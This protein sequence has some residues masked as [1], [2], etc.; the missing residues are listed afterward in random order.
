MANKR[1]SRF[2]KGAGTVA[3]RGSSYL[4]ERPRGEWIDRDTLLVNVYHEV[5]EAKR[6]LLTTHRNRINDHIES[7]AA[8]MEIF[9]PYDGEELSLLFEQSGKYWR[10]SMDCEVVTMEKLM[11]LYEQVKVVEN[12]IVAPDSLSIEDLVKRCDQVA[13][14]YGRG[15]LA[16]HYDKGYNVKHLGSIGIWEWARD[17]Y[18]KYRNMWLFIL[19]STARRLRERTEQT[20]VTADERAELMRQVAKCLGRS[21]LAT[22]VVIS[23]VERSVRTLRQC[24]ALYR[25]LLDYKAAEDLLQEYVDQLELKPDFWRLPPEAEEILRETT[26]LLEQFYEHRKRQ[27]ARR[28]SGR[29]ARLL[30]RQIRQKIL[31]G[32]IPNKARIVIDT[33]SDGVSRSS[34]GKCSSFAAYSHCLAERSFQR[35][36]DIPWRSW[37]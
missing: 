4:A 5:T 8:P 32:L 29:S 21:A 6:I 7:V 14:E 33:R 10:L 11:T 25:E 18:I 19:E 24:V 35:G 36:R 16:D 28:R 1:S 3:G 9:L 27:K 26:R 34:A 22:I 2:G 31:L 37:H 15:Y 30:G 23:E 13:I 20:D 12:G 17:P